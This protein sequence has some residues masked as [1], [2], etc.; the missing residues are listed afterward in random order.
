MLRRTTEQRRDND[1]LS[2]MIPT[3]TQRTAI[4]Y[5]LSDG[6]RAC[7]HTI[8]T[9]ANEAIQS[10]ATTYAGFQ[11]AMKDILP[12]LNETEQRECYDTFSDYHEM[13]MTTQR[14]VTRT[15]IRVNRAHRTNELLASID[16]PSIRALCGQIRG[17][18]NRFRNIQAIIDSKIKDERT[19]QTCRNVFLGK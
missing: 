13:L 18:L 17:L 4:P 2:L 7:F 9:F 10:A 19:L 3:N 14:F 5:S 1:D 12:K 15:L 16:L 11:G 6:G 8:T